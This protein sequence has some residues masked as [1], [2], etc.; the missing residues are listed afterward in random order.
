LWALV[1]RG[2]RWCSSSPSSSSSSAHHGSVD[3][4]TPAAFPFL[5]LNASVAAPDAI[6]FCLL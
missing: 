2:E 6:E 5:F 3:C 1:H 4:G